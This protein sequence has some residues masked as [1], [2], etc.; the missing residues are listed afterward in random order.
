M[1]FLK[2]FLI[3]ISNSL[4]SILGPNFIWL[5]LKIFNKA[6]FKNNLDLYYVFR[7]YQSAGIFSQFLLVL[8]QIKF[9]ESKKIPM[10]VDLKFYYNELYHKSKIN[11]HNY[12]NDYFLQPFNKNFFRNRKVEIKNYSRYNIS[13][14]DYPN[15]FRADIYNLLKFS[16]LY[17]R[18]IKLNKSLKIYLNKNISKIIKNDDIV[19]GVAVRHGYIISKPKDHD[20][21][22]NLTLLKKDIKILLSK[23]PINKILVVCDN[24]EFISKLKKVFK[25]KIIYIDRPRISDPRYFNKYKDKEYLDNSSMRTQGIENLL[26]ETADF[27]RFNE[28]QKKTKEYISEIYALAKCDHLLAGRSSGTLAAVIINGG[29]YKTSKLYNLGCY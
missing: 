15:I 4:I 25:K 20:I 28:K 1:K 27:N 10:Y 23:Y 3:K 21:Q 9:L 19:L 8:W 7:R 2:L 14:W 5:I 29:M 11:L 16:K 24:Y 26:L 17:K 12:W 22:P 18:Y 13:L 6:L